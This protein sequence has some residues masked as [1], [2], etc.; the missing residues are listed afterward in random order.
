MALRMLGKGRIHLLGSDCHDLSSRKPNLGEAIKVIRH[1]FGSDII[2][3]INS[4]EDEILE[5]L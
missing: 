1:K 4:N 3:Y 2:S 5:S